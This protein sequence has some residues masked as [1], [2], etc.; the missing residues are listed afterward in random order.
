MYCLFNKNIS[1][2]RTR[3]VAYFALNTDTV[4]GENQLYFASELNWTGVMKTIPALDPAQGSLAKV[5]M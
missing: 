2:A 4:L 3:T 5:F 1:S